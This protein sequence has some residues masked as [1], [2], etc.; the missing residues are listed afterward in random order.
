MQSYLHAAAITVAAFSCVTTGCTPAPTAPT[1]AVER[2]KKAGKIVVAIDATYPPMESEGA[3]GKPM[4]F[5]I[6]F[7]D[8]I[9]RRMGVTTEYVVMAWDGI[10]A[11][12]T[13]KRYDVIISSM[14]ITEDR[15]KTADFVEYVKMSQLFVCK[16]GVNVTKEQD[17]A[18]KSVAVQADTTSYEFLESKKKEGIAI[19]EVKAFKLATD[20]F[21]ALKAGQAEA[22]V[23]DEPVGRYYVKQDP[24]MF[25]ITGRA[26]APEPVGVALRKEDA[27]LTKEIGRIV[28]EMRADGTLK[29]ISEKWF[30]AE[31][32]A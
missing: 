9:A 7:A 31:L 20:A 15:K 18:G 23:I 4:G 3:D 11:G 29:K 32:G 17:L 5:D 24:A 28:D 16:Q 26:M 1:S 21:A 10:L 13:S 25:V 6:D 12:L 2:V 27:E 8:E 22:I 14:N 30:G 19:G